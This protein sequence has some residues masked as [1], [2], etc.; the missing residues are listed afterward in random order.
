VKGQ[1]SAVTNCE[2]EPTTA[3]KLSK[4]ASKLG[5]KID[6][7][8]GGTDK[9]CNG[10]ASEDVPP[11]LGWGGACPN[12]ENGACGMTISDC[13]DV[14]DCLE[15]IHTAATSQANDLYFGDM[16][17]PTLDTELRLCQ[18]AIGKEAQKFQEQKAKIIQKC[19]DKRLTAKHTDT[20]PNPLA[21]EGTISRKAADQIAQAESKKVSKICKACGGAD[22]LCNGVDDL[23]PQSEIGF[24]DNCTNVTVPGGPSCAG[25]VSTLED[26]VECV[27][28]V[29]EFKVDCMDRAAVPQFEDYPAECNP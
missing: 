18:E 29:T 22:A 3:N 1:I 9:V 28:C 8:C 12:F 2:A 5:A 4:A 26:L 19:W 25:A 14:A 7:S 24:Q 6:K 23:D 11:V 16:L 27:D 10:D 20:C 21:A 17:I 15:C 13:G